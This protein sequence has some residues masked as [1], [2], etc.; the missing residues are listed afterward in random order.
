VS[1][2]RDFEVKYQLTPSRCVRVIDGGVDVTKIDFAHETINLNKV[3]NEDEE[4]RL[5]KMRIH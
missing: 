5:A 3:G 1:D 2:V 4:Q